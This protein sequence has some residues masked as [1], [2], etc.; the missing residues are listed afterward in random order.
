LHTGEVELCGDAV[1]GIAVE[2]ARH[3]AVL[4]APGEILVSG[5]VKDLVAGSGLSFDDRG[6]H[7][8]AGL[9]DEWRV[10]TLDQEM[11]C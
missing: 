5:T 8:F 6:T 2:I 1:V 3:V 7:A 10:V 4:G 9:P 11:F